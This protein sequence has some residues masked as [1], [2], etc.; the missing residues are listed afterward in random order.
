M[1]Q[2]I[3]LADLF[4]CGTCSSTDVTSSG[5]EGKPSAHTLRILVG[6]SVVHRHAV[7]LYVSKN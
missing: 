7:M 5:R 4:L 1:R 3:K 2:F 6:A